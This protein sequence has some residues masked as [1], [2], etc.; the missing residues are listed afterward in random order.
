MAF[1]QNQHLYLGVFQDKLVSRI[2]G[3]RAAANNRYINILFH[4]LNTSLSF[5]VL[6]MIEEI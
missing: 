1:F 6:N 2:N 5:T 4:F 3:S